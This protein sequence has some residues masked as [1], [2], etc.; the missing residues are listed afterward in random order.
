MIKF[1]RKIRQKTLTENKFGKYL[2]YAIGEII[3]VV[4]GILIALSINTWNQNNQNRKQEKEILNQL[5]SEYKN[6]L[7]QLKSKISIRKE[8]VNSSIKLLDY[9]NSNIQS[10]NNDSLNNYLN[11]LIL[12][13]TFDPEL[14]VSGELINSG[15]LYLL[16]NSELRNKVSVF[17]S[18]LSELKEEETI[19][20]NWVEER[21]LPFLIE[22]YQIGRISTSFLDDEKLREIVT[23]IKFSKEKSLMTLFKQSD[24][25]ELLKHPDF[26]D[27]LSIMIVNT[28][29]TNDQS[30]GVKNKIEEIILR[31]EKEIEK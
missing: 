18:S 4:I 31:I 24:P 16:T 19:I 5:L 27:Y 20:V 2:T 23:Q 15:K 10:V 3:L 25:S 12:R 9:A 26:E 8:I 30:Y 28:I 7:T 11:L 21:I 14:S 22:H 6:N 17:S 13:P 29:Y 1:F